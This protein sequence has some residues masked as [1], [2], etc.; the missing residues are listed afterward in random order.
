MLML[1]RR[2]GE[3]LVLMIGDH[4]FTLEVLGVSGNR[5]KIGIRAP[6][7]VKVLRDELDQVGEGDAGA[8]RSARAQQR[9]ETTESLSRCFRCDDQILA[10]GRSTSGISSAEEER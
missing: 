1:T 5:T 9:V 8:R 10:D 7:E 4:R 3:G 6:R 2:R